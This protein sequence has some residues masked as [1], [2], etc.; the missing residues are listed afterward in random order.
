MLPT[1]DALNRPFWEGCAAGELRMQACLVCGRIRYPISYTCPN[2]LSSEYEWRVMSGEGEI[3]SWV[4]YQRNYHPAWAD[5]IPYNVVLIQLREGPRMFGNVE[6]LARTDL[7]VGAAVRVVF[8]P[9]VAEPDIEP[10][11]PVLIPRWRV[12]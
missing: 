7:S 4:V 2:C 3:L 1:I 8:V 5:R 9:V 6:P 10:A 11:A 12:V